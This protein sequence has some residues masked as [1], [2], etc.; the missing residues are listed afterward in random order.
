MAKQ[1]NIKRQTKE[2]S[3]EFDISIQ[4]V[5][6]LISYQYNQKKS[7]EW[8]TWEWG[9]L[10]KSNIYKCQ[11][12]R[13]IQ[14]QWQ[15]CLQNDAGNH[16]SGSRPQNKSQHNK[17]FTFTIKNKRRRKVWHTCLDRMDICRSLLQGNCHQETV[18]RQEWRV[19]QSASLGH[20]QVLHFWYWTLIRN[21]TVDINP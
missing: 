4:K 19:D 1:T 7:A 20:L 17:A 10:T 9:V 8:D 13:P 5:I 18:C 16:F 15:N 12:F 11:I 21:H 14:S 2:Y 6:L 3:F